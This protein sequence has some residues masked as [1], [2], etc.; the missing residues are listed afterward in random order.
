MA[1]VTISLSPSDCLGYLWIAGRS[2]TQLSLIAANF[3]EI[4]CCSPFGIIMSHNSHRLKRRRFIGSIA[5]STVAIA[6]CTSSDEADE[7]GVE[8]TDGDTETE[9]N[10]GDT[11]TSNDSSETTEGEAQF[12][13]VE[14]NY[15]DEVEVN[16]EFTFSVTVENTGNADGTW[17]QGVDYRFGDND[18][19]ELGTI[20]LDVPAGETATFESDAGH[21]P[22]QTTFR[23]RFIEAE[24]EIAINVVAA[25]LSL[26]EEFVAVNDMA[27]SV[28][29]VELSPYYEYEGYDGTEREHAAD[30]NQWAFVKYRAE[31]KGSESEFAPL[32]TDLSVIAD[33]RQYDHQYIRKED[34]NQY[35]GG[36]IEAGIVRE[37]WLAYE[38][39]DSLSKPDVVVSWSGENYQGSWTARWSTGF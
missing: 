14:I 9:S 36:E 38:I 37:G 10:D 7:G 6:G 17:T 22:Y 39:P 5:L 19:E 18:W 34:W 28:E 29:E 13:I 21:V 8:N 30:G 24:R 16:E 26:G 25:R 2:D 1:T 12:E 23:Y 33:N 20:E 32:E 27:L 3:Y 35:D 11:T 15:P 4:R 31:N